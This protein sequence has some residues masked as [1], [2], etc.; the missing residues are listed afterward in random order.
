MTDEAGRSL[1]V[2][3]GLTIQWGEMNFIKPCITISI[4][5]DGDVEAQ[6][7]RGLA[8]ADVAFARID[9]HIENVIA[10][11]IAPNAGQPGFNER[12]EKM[13]KALEIARKNIKTIKEKIDELIAAPQRGA[14][15]T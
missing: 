11:L 3:L 6:L 5:P 7:D 4:D 8:A 14:G 1:T 12:V 9:G 15:V 13:E 10:D 2:E